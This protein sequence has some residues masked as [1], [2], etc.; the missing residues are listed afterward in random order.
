M[1]VFA[2]IV[3]G[4]Q[5]FTIVVK[6]PVIDLPV[7]LWRAPQVK[8][9]LLTLYMA[10]IKVRVAE[11]GKFTT[12]KTSADIITINFIQTERYIMSFFNI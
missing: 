12:L 6:L 10:E 5:L 3:N 9:V 2:T 4:F 1:E 7:Y 8:Q 11:N